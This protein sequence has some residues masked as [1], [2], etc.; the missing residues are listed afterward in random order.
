MAVEVLPLKFVSV[1]VPYGQFLDITIP[2]ENVACMCPM[3]KRADVGKITLNYVPHHLCVET[4]SFGEYLET[5]ATKEMFI[6]QM[7]LEVLKVFMER[8]APLS[9]TVTGDFK[10]AGGT[11]ISVSSSAKIEE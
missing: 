4:D 10:Q 9:C 7:V 3:A 5:F 6:E 11:R 8:I 1:T 2:V